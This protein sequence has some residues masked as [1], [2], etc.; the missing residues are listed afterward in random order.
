MVPHHQTLTALTTVGLE[1]IVL[2]KINW[3]HFQ[4]IDRE[5]YSWHITINQ[6]VC[7]W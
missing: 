4:Q 7:V 5:D 1:V 6:F 2:G 3:C